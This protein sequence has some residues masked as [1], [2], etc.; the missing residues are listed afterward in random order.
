MLLMS[1]VDGMVDIEICEEFNYVV[2][3]CS[4]SFQSIPFKASLLANWQ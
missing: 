1:G 2:E 3:G 4:F